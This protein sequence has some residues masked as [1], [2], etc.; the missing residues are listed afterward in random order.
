MCSA[1]LLKLSLADC[2][3]CRS[4]STNDF[5][6]LKQG[7]RG[8]E[9]KLNSDRASFITN[10]STESDGAG[11]DHGYTLR[12]FLL[13]AES[14][15][16]EPILNSEGYADGESLKGTPPK[17][18]GSQ[19]VGG[20]LHD[21]REDFN[22]ELAAFTFPFQ[23]TTLA[24]PA[25]KG[26]HVSPELSSPRRFKAEAQY[27][28]ESMKPLKAR[29]H[30][31]KPESGSVAPSPPTPP[32]S[33]TGRRGLRLKTSFSKLPLRTST[34]KSNM[35]LPEISQPTPSK[36]DGP[37]PSASGKIGAVLTTDED[38]GSRPMSGIL[39]WNEF[40]RY[41]QTGQSQASLEIWRS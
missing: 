17:H 41:E 21:S 22:L 34:S 13:D 16:D 19:I 20:D 30:D 37:K 35:F 27:D 12:K 4:S 1:V 3:S 24:E 9:N 40:L 14:V 26:D 8:L 29:K 10:P 2:T 7:I 36:L 5:Q 18:E 23:A 39:G 25:V 28:P 33:D 15:M 31:E 6:H 32:S 38:C 11:T